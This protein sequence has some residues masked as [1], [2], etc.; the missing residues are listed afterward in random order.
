MEEAVHGQEKGGKKSIFY[1]SQRETVC[2]RFQS[3]EISTPEEKGVHCH[4][5]EKG[6]GFR[7][8]FQTIPKTIIPHSQ[9]RRKG[10]RVAVRKG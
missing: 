8:I 1:K 10:S 6:G 9:K 4:Q 5:E 3:R 7:A 2:S